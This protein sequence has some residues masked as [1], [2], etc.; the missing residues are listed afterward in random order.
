MPTS[1]NG[2]DRQDSWRVF[3]IMAEFVEGFEVMAPV[4]KAVTLFGSA[5][6][7]PDDPFYKDAE[8]T[9]RLLAKAGF[10]VIT[11][12]GPGIM[13]A[14]SKG[15][16]EAGGQSVGCNITL[17]QEQEANKYQTISLDFHYFYARKVMF[18]KYGSAFISFPGGY[19]TLDETFET[20]TLIQTL[21]VEAFP[22]ILYGSKH[23]N[24]LVDW[25]KTLAPE[26]LDAEDVEIFKLV[27]DP[28]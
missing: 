18:T 8:E 14:A 22:V 4:G 10:A 16:F 5:R 11:G 23:W 3:R 20:L 2:Q 9:G 25:V 15:A 6:T 13:E 17:P 7:R 26:Y 12:G 19:G 21:K 27:D 28:A 1:N 24:G